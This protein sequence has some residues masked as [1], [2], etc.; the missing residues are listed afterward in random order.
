MISDAHV[1]TIK[2]L[3]WRCP[4]DFLSFGVIDFKS[5]EYF[6][7]SLNKNANEMVEIDQSWINKNGL[8]TYDLASLTKPLSLS[9]IFLKDIKENEYNLSAN[10]DLI[11]LLNHKASLPSWSKIP[12]DNW[13]E[14]LLNFNIEKSKTCYS[15][16]SALRLMIQLESITGKSFESLIPDYLSKEII[17]WTKI[18]NESTKLK[19]PKTGVRNFKDINA[20]VNDDNAFNLGFFCSHAGLFGS[21]NGVC[22]SLINLDKKYN[23][24]KSLHHLLK[25]NNEK[26]GK[27]YSR[28]VL[29]WDTPQ[30]KDT[31]AG[32]GISKYGF[33]HLGF[34]GTSLW[35]DSE[36]KMGHVILTN[37]T[38]NYSYEKTQLNNLRRALGQIVWK[39]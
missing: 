16:L 27:Y 7:L 30:G 2:N 3:F 35:I 37:A 20:Q 34:T 6:D 22:E 11:L 24:L 4:F 21:I 38:Q 5:H 15:D 25:V 9:S 13:R 12:K 26:Q 29:G 31:L 19:F 23:L 8:L 10:N 18:L 14:Y 33:G 17:H 32:T 1:K 39:L 28:F 36:T